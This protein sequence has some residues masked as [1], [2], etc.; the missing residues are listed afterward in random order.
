MKPPDPSYKDIKLLGTKLD[1]RKD[2]AARKSKVWNPIK[3]FKPY[4][5]SKR[6]TTSHKI[7]IYRTYIEPILLYNSETW[8]LTTTLEKELNSFHRKLLRIS[9]NYRYPK[10]IKNNKLYKLTQENPISEKIK[11]RRLNLFG[12]ILRL[13]PHTPAQRA[14]QIYLTPQKRPV[15]RPPLTWLTQI[16]KDLAPTLKVNNIKPTLNNAFLV[17]IRELAYD[18]ARWRA[19]VARSMQRNL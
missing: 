18:R 14:L 15:G 11:K 1:T 5:K 9:L 10:T 6:L 3:K 13:H 19:E 12:H 17:G 8:T 7:R 2:I 4:F 16:I